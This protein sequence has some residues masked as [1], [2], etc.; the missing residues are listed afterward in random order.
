LHRP[1]LISLGRY[2]NNKAFYH[3]ILSREKGSPWSIDNTTLMVDFA[4]YTGPLIKVIAEVQNRL[5]PQLATVLEQD[6]M[7]QAT[8]DDKLAGDSPRPLTMVAVSSGVKSRRRVQDGANS[9]S[10]PVGAEEMFNHITSNAGKPASP[11]RRSRDSDETRPRPY[12]LLISPEL[13]GGARVS[14]AAKDEIETEKPRPRSR[15]NTA[16]ET[17]RQSTVSTVS[18]V[19]HD[20][21]NKATRTTTA[22]LFRRSK[23][24]PR[25]II[26]AKSSL[27]DVSFWLV[28]IGL[29]RLVGKFYKKKVDGNKLFLLTEKQFRK[30]IKTEDDFVLFKRA[31]RQAVSYALTTPDVDAGE[32]GCCC[33]SHDISVRR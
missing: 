30:L 12:S 3:H 15:L 22:T 14:T 18:T 13:A 6:G 28:S 32:S 31:L 23:A 20:D 1:P 33:S 17:R 2:S 4:P 19:E 25:C 7:V 9:S 21:A 24:Q 10:G 5:A 26:T 8:S 11:R 29:A 27:D 16:P